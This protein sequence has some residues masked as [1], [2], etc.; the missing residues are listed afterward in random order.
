MAS[1][2][3]SPI[4]KPAPSPWK[5]IVVRSLIGG[6]ACGLVL[7]L[8]V[9]GS[10][11]YTER[12]KAWNS[13]AVRTTNVKAQPLDRVNDKFEEVHSGI[14]FM[15]ALENTTSEDITI[16]QSVRIEQEE[17]SSHAL[18]GSFL[19][20]DHDVFLPSRH[21]VSVFLDNSDLCAAKYEPQSCFNSYFQ[22]F[23]NIVL[24][25]S[26]QKIE[27]RIPIPKLTVIQRGQAGNMVVMPGQN[28]SK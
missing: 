7:A 21:V 6:A 9:I 25:D 4:P 1:S 18:H 11:W 26:I 12:P 22:D 14:T 13:K 28:E 8:V 23:D 17:K 19:R 20:L 15:V 2:A 3:T 5:R 27:I 24:F 10:Y 16:P